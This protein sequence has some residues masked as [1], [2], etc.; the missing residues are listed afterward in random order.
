MDEGLQDNFALAVDERP[1]GKREARGSHWKR[2]HHR[3][4]SIDGT[5]RLPN[6]GLLLLEVIRLRLRF[7]KMQGRCCPRQADEFGNGNDSSKSK[8]CFSYP[9]SA[10]L[11]ILENTIRYSS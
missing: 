6:F 8:P 7:C 4:D 2:P 9:C 3:D 11:A 1:H 5:D 10:K